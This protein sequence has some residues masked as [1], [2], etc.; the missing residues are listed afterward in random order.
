MHQ[1][2]PLAT[3]CPRVVLPMFR[4]GSGSVCDSIEMR[5]HDE[6][7][8]DANHGGSALVSRVQSPDSAPNLGRIPAPC[9]HRG[10]TVTV[11]TSGTVGASTIVGV[12]AGGDVAMAWLPVWLVSKRA[13][14]SGDNARMSFPQL[15]CLNASLQLHGAFPHP[16][17]NTPGSC[18]AAAPHAYVP[19]SLTA[20]ISTFMYG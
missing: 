8:H 10:R 3:S 15:L 18:P 2:K 4:V 12:S 7:L 11:G 19:T 17:R 9:D 6:F 14:A 13:A 20:T 5:R 16:E 1:S